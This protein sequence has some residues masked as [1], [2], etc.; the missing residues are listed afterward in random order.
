M[1]WREEY[2]SPPKRKDLVFLG[3]VDGD[4]DFN[5]ASNDGFWSLFAEC[6]YDWQPVWGKS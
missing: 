4:G 1:S 5:P 6:G 3:W 2:A